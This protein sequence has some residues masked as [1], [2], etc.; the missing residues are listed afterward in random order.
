MHHAFF[1]MSPQE[2]VLNMQKNIEVKGGNGSVNTRMVGSIVLVTKR[3]G[4][5][6]NMVESTGSLHSRELLL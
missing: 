2:R 3:G 5:F 4:I 6:W 1:Q